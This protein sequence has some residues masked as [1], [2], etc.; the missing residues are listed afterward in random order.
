LRVK[1]LKEQ[2]FNSLSSK[3][4][5]KYSD[6]EFGHQNLKLRNIKKKTTELIIRIMKKENY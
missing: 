5:E 6:I 1:G 4:N 2:D 3:G